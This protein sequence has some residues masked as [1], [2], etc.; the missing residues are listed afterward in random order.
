VAALSLV[1]G[2]V[3]VVVRLA[4]ALLAL[5]QVVV[6]GVDFTRES[7]MSKSEVYPRSAPYRSTEVNGQPAEA[8]S[9]RKQFLLMAS[10]CTLFLAVGLGVGLF[11]MNNKNARAD[12]A[13]PEKNK[14]GLAGGAPQ[15]KPAP[16]LDDSLQV[17]QGD[18]NRST[19]TLQLPAPGKEKDLSLTGGKMTSQ[20]GNP[21]AMPEAVVE[22]LGGLTASHLYQTYLNIGL[23]ADSVEGEVY[24]KDEAR[25]LLDT[26]AGLMT[27]VDQQLD[28][29]GRQSLKAD[30]RKAVDQARVVTATLRSQTRELLEYWEKGEKDSVTRFHQARQDS[31]T[32]IKILLNIQE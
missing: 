27:A 17:E 18:Q 16:A 31:W 25:K 9:S 4:A 15:G 28:R 6:A 14:D 13:T 26:V 8:P 21:V 11:L 30:E 7:V 24:E 2:W 1:D 20:P 22:A 3:A 5:L 19:G 10:F 23:L 29:V 32:S 12:Q